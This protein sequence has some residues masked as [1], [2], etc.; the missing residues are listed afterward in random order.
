MF[1]HRE[2]KEL[3]ALNEQILEEIVII[4]KSLYGYST[5]KFSTASKAL[6]HL[7]TLKETEKEFYGSLMDEFPSA[8]AIIDN[9]ANI[10]GANEILHTFLDVSAKE[11]LG[12]PNIKSL[13]SYKQ[14]RCELCEFI[15]K[16]IYVDK[17]STFSAEGVIYI[18]TK[19]ERD[20]PVF[21]FVIP[22]YKD[23]ELQHSFL[24]LRDRRVE[25]EIRRNFMLDQSSPIIHMIKEIATGNITEKLSLP[26]DHQ[27]PHYQEPVNAII[28]S[29]T[30]MVLQIQTA[31]KESQ[32]SSNETHKH[33]NNLSD[34][35]SNQFMPTLSSI[36]ENANQLSSSI[37]QISSI[38]DLIKDVS[39]Q[40]NLL[41]LNAAIEAARAGEHG[42]GFAVVADEVRKL[43][44]K[45]Q[46]STSEIEGII[47]SIKDDSS[48][49]QNSVESFMSNSKEV[50]SI[51]DDLKVNIS[52]MVEHF[53]SLRKSS[54]QF[55]L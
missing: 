25:F 44:E 37:L 55:K 29:L 23:G 17:K 54:E 53:E 20:I 28:G 12:K 18:S 13:V 41:A 33:L 24:I 16:V 47:S 4:E 3:S 26:E 42:R 50:V 11:I 32:E 52:K 46:K 35:S 43:A 2:K 1:S 45:S 51:S 21:V 22:V 38:I 31:I 7:L 5:Y 48:T 10:I 14:N 6:E 39:D 49:M 30:E 19:K 8:V 27:L 36:S 34:W 15:E 40:T 9:R